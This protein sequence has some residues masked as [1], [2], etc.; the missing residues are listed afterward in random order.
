MRVARVSKDR[1]GGEWLFAGELLVIF[2]SS[3]SVSLS[4]NCV[5][6]STKSS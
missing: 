5:F 4:N 2:G 1:G 3:L 6:E